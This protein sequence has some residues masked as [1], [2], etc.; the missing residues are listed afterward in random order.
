MQH[1]SK[2]LNNY[3]HTLAKRILSSAVNFEVSTFN[4]IYQV[5]LFYIN[6]ETKLVEAY[7][8]LQKGLT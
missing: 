5:S 6:A 3:I 1:F 2:I 8:T 4:Y 7:V